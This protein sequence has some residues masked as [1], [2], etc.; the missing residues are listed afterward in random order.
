MTRMAVVAVLSPPSLFVLVLVEGDTAP[1]SKHAICPGQNEWA[2][3][4]ESIHTSPEISVGGDVVVSSLYTTVLTAL[5]TG[6]PV[7]ITVDTS[8]HCL[9]TVPHVE[10]GDLM[11]YE[12]GA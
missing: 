6:L 7:L 8:S 2:Y 1:L 9:T 4:V 11:P 5:V 10:P 3:F 12:L